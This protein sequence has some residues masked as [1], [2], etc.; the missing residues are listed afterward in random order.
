MDTVIEYIVLCFCILFEKE[1]YRKE[2]SGKEERKKR[3]EV[4]GTGNKKKRV[5]MM[6]WL[7]N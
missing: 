1:F 3:E 2:G 6:N 5:R 4:T 7:M